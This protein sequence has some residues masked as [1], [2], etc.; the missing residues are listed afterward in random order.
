[1][2]PTKLKP[3]AMRTQKLQGEATIEMCAKALEMEREGRDIVRMEIGD[4]D[5]ATP[6]HIT[7][8]AGAFCAASCAAVSAVFCTA[9]CAAFVVAALLPSLLISF[10]LLCC[11]R[12]GCLLYCAVT[13]WRGY[14]LRCLRRGYLPSLCLCFHCLAHRTALHCLCFS[15]STSLPRTPHR[16]SLPLLHCL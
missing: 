2:E 8:A 5:F 13:F 14:L 1:M 3:V 7:D 4:P 15:A 12:S 10:S 16:T 11:L 9:F 6:D